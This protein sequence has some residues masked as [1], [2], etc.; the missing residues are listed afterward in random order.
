VISLLNCLGKVSE[1]ILAKRLSYLAE[2]THLLH[3]TQIGGRFKKS[4]IDACLLLTDCVQSSK[5]KKHTTTALFLDIKG[6]FDH[7]SR[8]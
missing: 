3:P 6:A 2:T 8:G 5:L 7:V 4:A 1:Q